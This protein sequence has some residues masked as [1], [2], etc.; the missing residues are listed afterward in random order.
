MASA[1]PR[2]RPARKKDAE[3]APVPCPFVKFTADTVH[4]SEI[5][6]AP[7]NPRRIDDN[8]RARLKANLK[9]VG[10]LEPPIWNARTGNLVGGH[11]RLTILDALMGTKDYLVPV[12]RVDLE[13]QVEKEQNLFLNNREAQGDWDLAKL[14][15]LFREGAVR[16]EEAGFDQAQVYRLFGEQAMPAADELLKLSDQMRAAQA[17]HDELKR[18]V[19]LRDSA[20]YYKVLVFRDAEHVKEFNTAF[21]LEDSR[22]ADGR[23]FLARHGGPKP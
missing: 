6:G 22:F 20:G 5:K 4:R 10:L 9:T 18:K 1:K 17:A 12:A 11:Q 3:P 19:R 23:A 21:G 14:G 7:Y 13:E 15:S 2:K 8:A 16:T